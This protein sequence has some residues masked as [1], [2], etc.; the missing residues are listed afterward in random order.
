MSKEFAGR[1][2]E[3]RNY[4]W[5]EGAAAGSLKKQITGVGTFCCWG[6]AYDM[7][8]HTTGHA[9]SAIIEREDGSLLNLGLEQVR[10]ID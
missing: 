9:T 7:E 1:K 5:P 3:Y 2:V 6:L 8:E 10:F 4:E